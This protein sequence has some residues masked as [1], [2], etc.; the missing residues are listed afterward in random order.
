MIGKHA[1]KNPDLLSHLCWQKVKVPAAVN[2]FP[3]LGFRGSEL[4]LAQPGKPNRL[5]VDHV[6]GD[7]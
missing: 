2:D 4:L 6:V 7:H 5:L 3:E 1:V